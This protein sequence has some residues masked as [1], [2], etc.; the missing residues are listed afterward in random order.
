MDCFTTMITPYKSDGSVDYETA[1]KYVRWYYDAGL[2]GIFSVCQSSEIFYLSLEERIKLNQC[3]Y[4]A[5]KKLE[6]SGNRKFTVVSSG[7]VSDSMDDQVRELNEIY[8][9]GTDAIIMI[10]NRL[11]PSN[12][13]DDEFIKNAEKIIKF[14]RTQSSDCTNVRIRIRDLLHR[15]FW[16]GAKVSADLHI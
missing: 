2:T 11:D 6:K 14:H 15:V 8:A 4:N 12:S 1:E 13:G 5:A 9:S 10:T 3:V 7:H 16:I